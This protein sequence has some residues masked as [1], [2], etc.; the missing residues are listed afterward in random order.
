MLKRAFLSIDDIT[1]VVRVEVARVS[2]H[3]QEAADALLSLLLR[4]LLHVDGL[5]CV[6][7]V[8]ED[9]VDEL[10]EL[11]RR[12]IVELHHAQMAHER[13]AVKS[14][15]DQLDLLCVEVGRLG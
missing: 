4:L 1:A 3:L 2:Q 10:K 8:R 11:E 12:L 15:Y 14:V 6:V 9:S 5:V 13:R 7:E